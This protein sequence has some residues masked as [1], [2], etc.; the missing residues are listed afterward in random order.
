M[1][2]HSDDLTHTDLLDAARIARVY[3]DRQTLHGS[4]SRDH[5][6]DVILTGESKR[7]P[8]RGTSA[9]RYNPDYA[10]TWDQWGVFLAVLFERDNEMS[11]PYYDSYSAFHYQTGHRFVL[12]V[13]D[14][15]GDETPS[16][17]PSD[18]HGDHRFK[19]NGT[20]YERKCTK[21]TAVQRWSL[22]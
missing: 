8:N 1:R 22:R 4:R 20:P 13:S 17:W 18:A 15:E 10:A 12:G 7:R 3:F 2:I 6:F 16:H 5:A 11:V 9:D 14:P 19:Y 21:C